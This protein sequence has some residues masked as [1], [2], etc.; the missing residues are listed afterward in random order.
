M[1]I[2][3]CATVPGQCPNSPHW[4]RLHCGR[5]ELIVWHFPLSHKKSHGAPEGPARAFNRSQTRRG[6]RLRVRRQFRFVLH[7]AQFDYFPRPS[8]TSG[9]DLER[10]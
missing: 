4:S 5:C 1:P 3:C 2:V 9:L 10:I 8:G 7:A 6:L